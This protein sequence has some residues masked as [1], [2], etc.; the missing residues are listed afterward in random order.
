MSTSSNIE[1]TEATWNPVIG[2]QKVS[3][4]CANCYAETMARRLA[5]M[6]DADVDKGR[7]PS[8]RKH[9]YTRVVRYKDGIA[10]AQWNG[11]AVCVPE[12]LGD[13]L[14]WRKPRRVFVNSMSDLFH[15]DVPF[16][17]ID[18]V[19]AVM[20][21]CPQHTFQVLTKRPDRMA[22]Y[23][24]GRPFDE[25][26]WGVGRGQL[27]V[28][29]TLVD[30]QNGGCD[31]LNKLPVW[32]ESDGLIPLARQDG[33]APWPLPNVWLGTSV[34]NQK[35]ADERIPHLLEC[36]AAVRWLSCEPLLGE[37]ILAWDKFDEDCFTR[38]FPLHGKKEVWLHERSFDIPEHQ[39][40]MPKI[41]WVV[42]GGE[43]G[44]GA[45]QMDIAW[46]RSLRDQCQRAGVPFFMKQMGKHPSVEYNGMLYCRDCGFWPSDGSCDDDAWVLRVKDS[47]GGDWSEWPEEFRVR[48]YP[49]VTNAV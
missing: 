39:Q 18:Q 34:E 36:P 20:A 45:R 12:A 10:L 7:P 22:E 21:L 6:A 48:E 29:E 25:D 11:K 23:F 19:F 43:S 1:W 30:W 8:T 17:F 31:W 35:V 49:E 3:P 33:H 26:G 40:D 24:N 5:Y 46:A 9:A 27:G 32:S 44:Y 41:D 47:K 42:A 13:P 16:E 4:G 2:C 37:V 28:D 14:K 15:E 38:H